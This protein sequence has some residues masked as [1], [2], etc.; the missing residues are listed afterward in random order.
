MLVGSIFPTVAVVPAGDTFPSRLNG[1]F[2][3]EVCPL[4]DCAAEIQGLLFLIGA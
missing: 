2:P 3:F 4:Y 1:E